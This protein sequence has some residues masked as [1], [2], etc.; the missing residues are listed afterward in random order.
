MNGGA[1]RPSLLVA[2]DFVAALV[3]LGL[4]YQLRYH[5]Y[6]RYIPGGVPPDPTH[7]LLAAPVAAATLVVVFAAVGVYRIRRGVQF[8]DELFSVM[9]GMAVTALVVFA[10]IGLYREDR[11]TFSRLSFV[12]WAVLT[13]VLIALA[14]WAI[15]RYQATQRARGVGVDRALVVGWGAAADLLVQRL[16]MFPDYGYRVVGVLADRIDSGEEIGGVPVLGAVDEVG[17]VI[18]KQR[19]DTV[20]VAL[21]DVTPDRTLRL[22]DCCRDAG[23]QFRIL[24]GMLEL[25][26]TQ[27]TADQIDGIPLLQLRHGLD[28]QG[29]K[30]VV[31]RLFDVAVAGLA[32]VVLAPL[33][34][35]IALLVKLTSPGPLLIHQDRIGMRGRIFK[36]HKFRSMRAGA[37]AETGPV[38]AAPDDDRRTRAGRLLRR[39]SLDELPQLWNIVRGEMSLVGPRPERPKFVAEFQARLPQYDDR[40]MVRPGLA[41]WA[42]ANDLR[43]QT[44]VEERLIY[45]LYYIENWSLAFDIKILLITLARV[46][47]HKNAY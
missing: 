18:R 3:A 31:K 16:R 19:V 27:V 15:R 9:G 24:P 36:T 26:T 25:M 35:V 45:D 13:T 46:W 32:L 33:M 29:P 43:G 20:F 10:M 17:G 7:Y 21:S 30:T 12:Y 41:G 39:L 14:R 2:S 44:P 11:F 22:I 37:E 6:P 1:R 47:T 8:V 40:H 38:W 42:Q 28:I 34:A 5:V 4:A 23:I